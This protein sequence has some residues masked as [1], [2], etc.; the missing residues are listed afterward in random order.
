VFEG[1]VNLIG[2]K[3]ITFSDTLAQKVVSTFF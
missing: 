1:V 3:I 2:V